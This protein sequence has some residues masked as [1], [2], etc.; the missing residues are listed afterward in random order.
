MEYLKKNF[1]E[2]KITKAPNI[3]LKGNIHFYIADTEALNQ[4]ILENEWILKFIKRDRLLKTFKASESDSINTENP[5]F[6]NIKDICYDFHS[7]NDVK[8]HKN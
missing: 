4:R 7:H 1:Y 2:D 8:I 6:P 5:N 3:S